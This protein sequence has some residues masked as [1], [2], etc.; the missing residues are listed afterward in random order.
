MAWL[1]VMV[2]A[3]VAF[4]KVQAGRNKAAFEALIECWAG[5]LVSDGYGVYGQWVYAR[6]SCL[7]HL[8]RRARGLDV[9]WTNMA[10]TS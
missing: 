5:I 1:W 7:A 2:N 9:S 8:I 10:R 6:Q 4:F 3:T